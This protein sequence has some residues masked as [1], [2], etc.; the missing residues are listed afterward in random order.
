[1]AII[2]LSAA[3]N[4]LRVGSE[5]A[6][7]DLQ[8]LIDSATGAVVDFMGRPIEGEGGWPEGEVPKNVIHAVKVALVVF[9]DNREA[10]VLDRDVMLA[11]V[12]RHCITSFA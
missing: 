12:G 4:W 6:D 8:D 3:R 1:M 5:V 7:G 11:L 9:Y 2:T 10:P